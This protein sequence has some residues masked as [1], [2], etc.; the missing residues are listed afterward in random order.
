M[1]TDFATISQSAAAVVALAG[2]GVVRVDARRRHPASGIV[3]SADGLILTAHHVVRRDDSISVGLADGRDLLATLVGRDPS[4]DLALLRVEA[5]GL[6]AGE[7]RAEESLGVGELVL[8]LG[9]PGQGVQ[10]SLGIISA[11]GGAWRSLSGGKVS[12]YIRPDLVMYPGFSG[13]PLIDGAGKVIGLATSALTREGGIA[14]S[15]ATAQLVVE[16][17]LAHGRMRRGYLGIGVQPAKL[18]A[19]VA[20]ALE[21]ETGVLLN[22]IEADSPAASAGLLVGDILVGLDGEAVERPEDLTLLLQGSQ[23]GQAVVAQIVRGGTLTELSV[24]VGER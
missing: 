14:L 24:T 5:T 21:R 11:L 13:G 7:W 16:T 1:S 20:E 22:S 23:V 9:R 12:Y 6:A 10:A 17:L 19:S 8:A 15:A 4:T 3:W 2:Q 18:P